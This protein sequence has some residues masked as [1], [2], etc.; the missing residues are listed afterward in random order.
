MLTTQDILKL[1]ALDPTALGAKGTLE[2]LRRRTDRHELAARR[3]IDEL[4]AMP[5]RERTPGYA[6]PLNRPLPVLPTAPFTA[7]D[8]VWLQRLPAD[9]AA[10]SDDDVVQLTRLV[11]TAE[12]RSGDARL[13]GSIFEP[14]RRLH[15]RRRAEA[16]LAALKALSPVQTPQR[17]SEALAEAVRSEVPQLSH[18]EAALR[19]S[20][21]INEATTVRDQ[22]H[23][24]RLA[25]AEAALD[26]VGSGTGT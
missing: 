13:V 20:R 12:P 18:D 16:E 3:I 22:A 4:R 10:I 14:V 2:S 7:S 6:S 5:T 15:A 17:L 25:A 23:A 21:M 11:A 8:V 1:V 19:A 24:D 26:L 9:P